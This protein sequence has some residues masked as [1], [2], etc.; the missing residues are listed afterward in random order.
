MPFLLATP[1]LEGEGKPQHYIILLRQKCI[2][3]NQMYQVKIMMMKCDDLIAVRH[4]TR[5]GKLAF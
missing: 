2:I 5:R 4:D 3:M 1:D